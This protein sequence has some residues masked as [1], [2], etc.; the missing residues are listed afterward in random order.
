MIELFKKRDF[1]GLAIFFAVLGIFTWYFI[2]KLA[3][4]DKLF[5]QSDLYTHLEIAR[6]WLQGRP[7]MHENCYGYHNKLHNYF[8]DLLMGPFAKQWGVYGIFGVQL[9]LH[10]WALAYTLPTLLKGSNSFNHKL[11]VAVLY[12]TVFS[13]PYAFWLYDDPH[14][15]FHT[16]MLYV[17][18]GFMFAVSLYK[19]QHWVSIVT[20]LLMLSVKEDGAVIVACIHL[21]YLA[22]QFI[23]KKI[24]PKRWLLQSL[25]WGGVWVAFFGASIYYLRVQNNFGYDRLAESFERIGLQSNNDIRA[26]FS[27]VFS[28]FGILLVPFA[29]ILLFIRQLNYKVWLA[30]LVFSV[31]IVT[32]NLISGFPYFPSPSFSLSWVPRF[33]LT[34]SFFLALCAFS[35]MYFPRAW[36]R[37]AFVCLVT[38]VCVGYWVF[39]LQSDLLEEATEYKYDEASQKIFSADHP[40]V[41]NPHWKDIHKVA[42]VLP[43]M[44][45][46][47]PPYATFGYFHK[48]DIIWTNVIFN[49]H[50]W[51]RMII[52]DESN[53]ANVIPD[54]LLQNPDSVVTDKLKYYFEKEDRHYLQ[55]A[56]ITP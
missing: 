42:D 35:L 39:V 29:V 32:V 11:V 6:G 21:L 52:C 34:F 10:I 33:S 43:E 51:P 16:E 27:S 25:L 50:V 46:I 13:G 5:Y 55:Q 40:E 14:Y 15:G 24:T 31:P 18:L 4:F 36:F 44:Y 26:Y 20:A 48:Q 38:A 28:S 3:L 2:A 17:P 45:P 47:A 49:A 12:I 37:P 41:Y 8:F 1:F 19:K 53:I 30:W 54:Q 23:A 22:M 56:G 9:A 7:L